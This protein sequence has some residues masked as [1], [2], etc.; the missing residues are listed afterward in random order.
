MRLHNKVLRRASSIPIR[1]GNKQTVTAKPTCRLLYERTPWNVPPPRFKGGRVPN[2]RNLQ[3]ERFLTSSYRMRGPQPLDDRFFCLLVCLGDEVDAALHLE[4]RILLRRDGGHYNPK[5]SVVRRRS[6]RRRNFEGD[7]FGEP[8]E[9]RTP[10]A[11]RRITRENPTFFEVFLVFSRTCGTQSYLLLAVLK[12][13][14][15]S[16]KQLSNPRRVALEQHQKIKPRHTCILPLW[17][18]SVVEQSAAQNKPDPNAMAKAAI[19]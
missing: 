16:R 9:S 10:T 13:R 8:C 5:V 15:E 12:R 3:R 19:L 11:P 7:E 17:R 2:G 14:D 4:P 18:L 6:E 1:P